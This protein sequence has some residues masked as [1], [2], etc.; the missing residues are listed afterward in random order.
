MDISTWVASIKSHDT[1]FRFSVFYNGPL[2]LL[3]MCVCVCACVCVCVCVHV[4]VCVCVCACVCVFV[5]V[6]MCVHTHAVY[7]CFLL[8]YQTFSRL[9]YPVR[10]R[11]HKINYLILIPARTDFFDSLSIILCGKV[12]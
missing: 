9:T 10:V 1:D 12:T 4:C 5:C 2:G 3:C 11:P 6:Y 7:K 8:C